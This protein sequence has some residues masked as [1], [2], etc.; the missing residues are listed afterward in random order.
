MAEHHLFP[1]IQPVEEPMVVAVGN[2]LQ[3]GK[4]ATALLGQEERL[5]AVVRRQCL[6]SEP[7]LL[8]ELVEYFRY[9]AA[10]QAD[11]VDGGAAQAR[12]VDLLGVNQT[13]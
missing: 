2:L 7:I 10:S 11:F 12:T 8:F 1:G 3:F 9:G 4:N 6:S 13:L 5:S